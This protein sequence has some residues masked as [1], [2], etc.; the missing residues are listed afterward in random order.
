[1]KNSL[2]KFITI[3]LFACATLLEPATT[4]LVHA[5]GKQT[6]EKKCLGC[7][8]ENKKG[9]IEAAHFASAQWARFFKRKSAH[10]A[11]ANVQ[12]AEQTE[13]LDYLRNHAADSDAPEVAGV[14]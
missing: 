6:W 9:P 7:H 12:D 2:Q 5:K 11:T 1:M 4:R 13:L 8:I 10:V 3:F 14:R